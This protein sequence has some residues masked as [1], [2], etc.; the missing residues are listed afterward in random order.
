MNLNSENVKFNV[1][2]RTRKSKRNKEKPNERIEDLVSEC[3]TKNK[4]V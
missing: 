4:N 1:K 3:C 2:K